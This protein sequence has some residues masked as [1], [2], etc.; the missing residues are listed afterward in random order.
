VQRICFV[1]NVKPDKLDDYRTRHRE[2]WPE[3]RDALAQ[4]GWRDY[5]LF[6]REDGLLVGYLVTD[7]FD[8]ARAAI[9]QMPINERW[10]EH[11]QP[12]FQTLD[13][14]ADDNMHPLDEV[15]HLD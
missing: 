8:R 5:S 14:H 11:M 6:L 2:V 4:A 15:F 3:M 10:Q 1:L 13:S 12:L 9:K 7:D